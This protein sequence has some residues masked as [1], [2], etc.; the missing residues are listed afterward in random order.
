[1]QRPDNAVLSLIHYS[2]DK[3]A[4]TKTSAEQLIAYIQY[5]ENRSAC[6]AILD[7]M[8]EAG[9]ASAIDL[10]QAGV[11]EA[12]AQAEEFQ[13]RGQTHFR[14]AFQTDATYLR[15]ARSFFEDMAQHG[16]EL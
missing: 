8:P 6:L 12:E 4:L 15:I 9:F 5:L 16:E 2:E 13:E 14:D 11:D 7:E 3:A 1:M 10:M